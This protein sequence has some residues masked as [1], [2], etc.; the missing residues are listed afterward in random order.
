MAIDN[1]SIL[2]YTMIQ[3]QEETIKNEKGRLLRYIKSKVN[4]LEDAEDI[5]QDV[6]E[7][8]VGGYGTIES[9]EKATSW[10]FKVAGNKI[11]DLYRYRNVRGYKVSLDE[12]LDQEE[13]PLMLGDILPDLDESPEEIYVRDLIWEE[14]TEAIAKLPEDQGQ[15]FILHE[16]EEM[17]FKEISILLD[18]PVN[19]LISRKRYAVMALRKKLEKLYKEIGS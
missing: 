2:T 14:I 1:T 16:F 5:L 19:T 8:F 4:N 17:S 10:L 3:R 15:V 6:L 9:I 7:Q 18:K 12:N 13:A 11:I